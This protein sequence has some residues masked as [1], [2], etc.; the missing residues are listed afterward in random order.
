MPR[1]I[2]GVEVAGGDVGRPGAQLRR[3]Q[4]PIAEEGPHDPQPTRYSS[5]RQH[6]SRDAAVA[7]D[8]I[9]FPPHDRAPLERCPLQACVLIPGD[10]AC[11]LVPMPYEGVLL[12][13]WP[14]RRNGEQG[15]LL[16]RAVVGWPG[17]Q[18]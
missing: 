2:R 8:I 14:G 5:K 12:V 16:R 17:G 1:R 3:R 13:V 6:P 7:A 4:R 11:K 15:R 10:S 9:R 18:G